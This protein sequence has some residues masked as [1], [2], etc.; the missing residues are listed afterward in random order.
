MERNYPAYKLEFLALKWAVA[1]H[2]HEYLYG[3]NFDVYTD[4]I[5]LMYTLTSAKLDAVSQH[6]VVA[7][8]SYN[9]QLHYKTGKSNVEGDALSGIPWQQTGLEC[10]DSDCQTVKVIIMGSTA[11]TSLFEAYS[12]KTVQAK[13]FQMIFNRQALYSLVKWEV[14]QNLLIANQDWIEQQSHDKTI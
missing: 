10:L 3:D 7:L 5:P 14:D 13:G 2:F 9:F 4:N 11:E 8:A 6:W 12:G 1:D